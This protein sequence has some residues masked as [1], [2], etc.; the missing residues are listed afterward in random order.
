MEQIFKDVVDTFTSRRQIGVCLVASSL[1]HDLLRKAGYQPTIKKGIQVLAGPKLY[2]F[3][4]WV[5]VGDT[6]LDPASEVVRTVSG[7]DIALIGGSFLTT[8]EPPQGFRHQDGNRDLV[9]S[10]RLFEVYTKQPHKYWQQ[11]PAWL[12]LK[13]KLLSKKVASSKETPTLPN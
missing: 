7:V 8:E 1:L 9:E 11:A 13:R 2:H 12:Q 5:E 10:E 3:H 4:V 6:K